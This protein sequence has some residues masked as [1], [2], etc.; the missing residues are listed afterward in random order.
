MCKLEPKHRKIKS[1][2]G[3]KPKGAHGMRPKGDDCKPKLL[4]YVLYVSAGPFV[5]HTAVVLTNCNIVLNEKAETTA[6]TI[7]N[8]TA[9]RELRYHDD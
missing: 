2:H 8:I 1:T 4:I 5:G 7:A 3:M 9:P 6:K